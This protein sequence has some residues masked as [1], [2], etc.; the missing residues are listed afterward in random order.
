[1]LSSS[2]GKGVKSPVILIVIGIFVLALIAWQFFKYRIVHSNIDKAVAEK[3]GGLYS[4]RYED[5]SIDEVAGVLH[6]KNIS[7][8]PD[9]ILYD[10]MVKENRNPS[11]LIRISVPALDILGVRTPKAL[12]TKEIEGGKIL[13]SNPTIEIELDHFAKDSAVSD[14]SKEI[15]KELLGKFLKIGVDSVEI[16]HANLVVRERGSK[17]PIFSG[18]N[19]S[20]LFTGL[21]IDSAASKDSSR[22]LF[23]RNM[24]MEADEIALPSKNKE[25]RLRVEKIRF[26]GRDNTIA[27]GSLRL[28]PQMGEAEFARSAGKQKDRYDF[29]FGNVRLAHLDRQAL[30][31]KRIEADS[32]V[33]GESSFKIFRDLSYPPDTV[34]KVGKY[35]QELLMRLGLP[36]RIGKMVFTNSFIEYK[37]K[38]G[39]SDSAGKVQFFNVQARIEN[40]TNMREAISRDNACVVNFRARFLDRAPVDARLVM[41]L[42]NPQGKFTIEG[43]VGAI[44]VMALNPLTQPMGLARMEKGRIDNLYFNFSATDSSSAGKLLIRYQDIRISLLKKDKEENKYDKKGLASL[45]AGILLKRSNPDKGGQARV[46]DVHFRRILNKSM[47]NL[48]WKSIFSGIKQTMGIKK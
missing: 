37:E 22:I 31:R 27:I 41:L 25:Y 7:I 45:A 9:T 12:L 39:K 38:N 43:N 21:L 6:V 16:I 30:W 2:K 33:V 10:Q 23:S 29:S 14:P 40:V 34:S 32:L 48:I 36:I 13:V 17:E 1:M 47:F 8:L 42:G 15:Y 24:D 28:I 20:F 18:G 44:D 35:P 11:V 3:S 46:E 26:T 19:V 5:L 4:V